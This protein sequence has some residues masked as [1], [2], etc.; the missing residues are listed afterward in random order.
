LRC[1]ASIN[2]GLRGERRDDGVDRV[3]AL[4][5]EGDQLGA[6]AHA[7]RDEFGQRLARDF[8]DLCAR[9]DLWRLVG[10]DA[11]PAQGFDDGGRGGLWH[12]LRDLL[13]DRDEA[14]E[15]AL[16]HARVGFV[17]TPAGAQRE[18][19]LELSAQHGRADELAQCR[20]RA[21]QFVGRT[22]DEVEEARVDTAQFDGE[23]AGSGVARRLRVTG[24]ALDRAPF[25]GSHGSGRRFVRGTL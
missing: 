10:D 16:V 11:G 12:R 23:L 14:G 1:Q 7:T 6:F 8:D 20:F 24:H 9:V 21:A 22:D 2:S 3:G 25:G 19:A 13:R 18:A 17:G 15:R 4:E 5:D